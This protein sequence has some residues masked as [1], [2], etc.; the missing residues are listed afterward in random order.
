M[1]LKPTSLQD[2]EL[3]EGILPEEPYETI[4]YD[5]DSVEVLFSE[6]GIDLVDEEPTEEY[7]LDH[8]ANL[9]YYEDFLS[10]DDLTSLA[11]DI[12]EDFEADN[13]SSGS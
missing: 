13:S 10:D 1:A 4:E 5:D 8:Y 3:P 9:V 11:E 6:G 7:H 12:L 2:F